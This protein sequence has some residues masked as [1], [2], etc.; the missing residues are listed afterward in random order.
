ME[1][2]LFWY[3]HHYN[4]SCQIL[5]T[6][7]FPPGVA[8]S[9]FHSLFNFFFILSAYLVNAALFQTETTGMGMNTKKSILEVTK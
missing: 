1:L 5:I 2:S 9:I 4:P 6:R 7:R 3:D 8:L